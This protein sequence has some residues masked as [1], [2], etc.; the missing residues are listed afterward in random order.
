MNRCLS[1]LLVWL[2]VCCKSTEQK[3]SVVFAGEVVNPSSDYVVL[4]KGAAI[5]DSTKLDA[6]NRFA[7]RFPSFDDGLYHFSHHPEVQYVY[8][9]KGDS[10]LVRLNTMY[11]DE[12]LVF[13]GS[14]EEVNNFLLELFLAE[15]EEESEI[16]NA[17]YAL[18]SRDFSKKIAQLRATKLSLLDEIRAESEISDKAYNLAKASVEYTYYRYKEIY[19]FEH[20]KKL[21]LH[22]LHELND[23]FYDYRKNINYNDRELSYL[24]PYYNFMKSHFGNLAYMTCKQGC[25]GQNGLA[26]NQ[27]HF[28]K[29]K[30]DV[31]D[32][33]VVEKE[34]R[35]NLF[36]NVAFDYLLKEHDSPQN[37]QSFLDD[38]VLVS[39]NNM[40]ISEIQNL[41]EGIRNIQPNNIIP[42]ILVQSLK[43]EEYNVQGIG[44]NRKT[45]FY[46]WTGTNKTHYQNIFKRVNELAVA[47]PDM[48]FVGIN[49]QTDKKI[50]K[51]IVEQ[52]GLDEAKQFRTENFQ[53]LTEK[54]ILYPMNKCIITENSKIVD[55]FSNIYSDFNNY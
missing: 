3:D 42:S 6:S 13:S 31:I 9:E 53:E 12:S 49:V 25:K 5:I 16:G 18:E 46:F 52:Q 44:E 37:N 38:F 50:W 27:L 22:G 41:H 23:T 35:D 14:N 48:H 19:P 47:K 1:F 7:F 55:A 34:L 32:S 29:H 21:R 30:L 43:D 26:N 45:V 17:Y 39:G 10:L 20:K 15:E 54:L 28:N 4:Y 33:L 2:L 11:F 8:L 40:H 51:G 36:R 24:R